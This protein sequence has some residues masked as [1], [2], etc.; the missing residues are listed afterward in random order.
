MKMRQAEMK[1]RLLVEFPELRIEERSVPDEENGFLQIHRLG[2]HPESYQFEPGMLDE[3]SDCVNSWD[4][5]KSRE[6][7]AKYPAF[8]TEAERI[9]SLFSQS[10]TLSRKDYNGFYEA[11]PAKSLS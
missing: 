5:E 3:L 10:S 11:R 8:V 7:L 9:A 4:S 1:R 6:F 2:K